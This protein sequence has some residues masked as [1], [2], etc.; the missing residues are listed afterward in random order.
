[1]LAFIVSCLVFVF[2][3]NHLT[4]VLDHDSISYSQ[5][6]EKNSWGDIYHAH[7]LLYG[8]FKWVVYDT[9]K[10]HGY[11]GRALLVNQTF[12]AFF[13]AFGVG[14]LFFAVWYI[15]G[16]IFLAFLSALFMTSCNGY[17][18]CSTFGGV[19]IMGTAFL[20]L[21]F[22][23]AAVFCHQTNIMLFA[24]VT[25][26]MFFKKDSFLKKA[27][28]LYLYMFLLFAI[29]AGLYWYVGWKAILA[30][31][32]VWLVLYVPFF[33]WW[34]RVI[35]SS[36]CRFFLFRWYCSPYRSGLSGI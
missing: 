10:S 27:S 17:W 6:I 19:R 22:L 34:N 16:S 14:V 25:C 4:A 9:L 1:M 5:A 21:T 36:G 32:L 30:A 28:Y 18:Y 12:N 33:I 15:S 26:M 31:S 3:T 24:V 2:Y 7:H 23:L 13:G 29:V 11:E 8:Y 20:L 35:R